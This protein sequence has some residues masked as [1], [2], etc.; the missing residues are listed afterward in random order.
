MDQP[1]VYRYP[2]LQNAKSDSKMSVKPIII[3]RLAERE[4]WSYPSHKQS[5]INN[6][7][8]HYDLSENYAPIAGFLRDPVRFDPYDNRTDKY[9]HFDVDKLSKVCPGAINK[10]GT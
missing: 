8:M 2:L 9:T 7:N 1:P 4:V 6:N 3:P 5:I 10:D